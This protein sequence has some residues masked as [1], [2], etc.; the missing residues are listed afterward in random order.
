MAVVGMFFVHPAAAW[1]TP[2]AK[3]GT[4][5]RNFMHISGMIAPTFMFLAGL[6]ISLVLSRA[7]ASGADTHKT[8][9]RISRR[10]VEILLLGYGMHFLMYFWS[11]AWG[12]LVRALKV[13]I[14]HCIGFTM[15]LLPWIARSNRTVN[16]PA[17]AL[18]LALP[19]LSMWMHRLPIGET[20]P[21]YLAGYLTSRTEYTLFPVI[22]Y[23]AWMTFGLFFGPLFLRNT[24]NGGRAELR[25]WLT[26]AA[27]AVLMWFG[28]K[29]I[30]I[31]Y[32][33]WN[34]HTWGTE[35]PQ[36]KGIPHYFW[37]KGAVL[38]LLLCAARLSTALFDR[39]SRR[40]WIL[41]GRHSLFAYCVHLLIIYPVSGA[42]LSKRLS[43]PEHLAGSV[44]LTG[45][46]FLLVLMEERLLKV[47][48]KAL[49]RQ[50]V[51]RLHRS[52]TR[53]P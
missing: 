39:F 38:L 17:L 22:P 29:G 37:M 25:F 42:Y 23:G 11:G 52:P 40:F 49:A 16:L 53:R 21:T 3:T 43:P 50:V 24:Q 36:V 14:L 13:D 26:V 45:T 51:G 48:W 34:L 44:I 12:P 15:A 19:F 1:L 20:L 27:A 35:T 47:Q 31:L 8:R 10:G 32:Y 6:A 33:A 9:L 30:K 46:M 4:Y 2:E 41:F 5:F 7:A 18:T 28:G